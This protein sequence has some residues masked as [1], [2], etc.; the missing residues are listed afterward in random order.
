MQN[1]KEE[2]IAYWTNRAP[3][4]SEVNQDELRTRQHKVW[5]K[6][7][8]ERIQVHFKGKSRENIR[9]LDVGTGPGFF[10][11]ILAELGYNV[12]AV[13]YTEAMLDEA[14]K[15]AGALTEKINFKRMNAEELA[16]SDG[17]FDVVVSRNLTWNL[18][19]PD[20]AYSQWGRVLKKGGLIM[21]FDANWYRYLY[22]SKAE[23]KHI[24]DRENVQASGAPDDTAGTDVAAMESI[25]RKAPLSTENRPS[26]DLK[27]LNSFGMQAVADTEVWKQVWT[28]DEL[29]NNASTPMFLVTATK[30]VNR[31]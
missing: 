11:I 31:L 28:K 22:D 27:I 3:S 18:P 24:S 21:N 2:N 20:K 14:R 5:G 9:V 19:H 26:W 6:A 30:S 13:D 17:S 10:A 15:N 4:Y 29:I 16:F 25:A 1:Y 23:E 12:T 7:L 8:D